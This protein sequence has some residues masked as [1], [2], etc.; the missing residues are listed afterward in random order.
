[1]AR[2]T[3]YDRQM[4]SYRGFALLF[5]VVY[6]TDEALDLNGGE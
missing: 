3:I 4:C 6:V 5:C 1:M 2:R